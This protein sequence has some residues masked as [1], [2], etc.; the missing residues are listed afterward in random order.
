MITYTRIQIA[1]WLRVPLEAVNTTPLSVLVAVIAKMRAEA[2]RLNAV[3]CEMW[4]P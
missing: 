4:E 3:V 1:D 2:V